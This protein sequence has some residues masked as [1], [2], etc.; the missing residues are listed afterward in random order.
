M[1][2]SMPITPPLLNI[3]GEGIGPVGVF[4]SQ[5]NRPRRVTLKRPVRARPASRPKRWMSTGSRRLHDMR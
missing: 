5:S 3:V 1:I 2:L 4:V